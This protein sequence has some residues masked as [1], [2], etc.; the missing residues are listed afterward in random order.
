M[1]WA[2]LYVYSQVDKFNP[3]NPAGKPKVCETSGGKK[4]RGILVV[5]DDRHSREGLRDSLLS[6]GYRVETAPDSW[7]AI[8]K[9]KEA[10]Y[11]VAIIDLDLPAVHGVVVTGWDLARIFPAY[12]PG[13]SI[14]LISA[15]VE[16]T[17]RSR[18]GQLGVSEFLEK[19]ISPT[20][21]RAIV[22]ALGSQGEVCSTACLAGRS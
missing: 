12:S 19:P 22:R 10:D 7:Q 2:L 1:A 15:E 3:K 9:I 16:K 6:E 18:A 21:L 4:A 20:R 5:D 11:D 17:Q 13:I 14:I 8:R